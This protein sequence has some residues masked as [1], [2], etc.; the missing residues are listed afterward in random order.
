MIE[1]QQ[2]TALFGIMDW[3]LGHASRSIPVIRAFEDQG[4]K[5]IITSSGRALRLL[6][7]EFPKHELLELP[8]YAPVYASSKHLSWKIAP[9]IPHFMQII[10][11]EKQA[12]ES[13]VQKFK[14]SVVFSDN[15]YGFRSEKVHSIFMTHQL[16]IPL[17]P[18]AK[19]FRPVVDFLNHRYINKFN[20]C[21]VP[22]YAD[23]R[24]FA[25]AMSQ[26]TQKNLRY[27]GWISRFSRSVE[28]DHKPKERD[29]I[30]VL[31]GPEPQRSLFERM[32]I[33]QLKSSD[34]RALIVGGKTEKTGSAQINDRIEHCAYLRAD[35]L[36]AQMLSSKLVICRS[37]YSSLMDLAFLQ[38]NAILVPTPGQTEQEKLAEELSKNNRFYSVSQDR[39][40]LNKAVKAA[41]LMCGFDGTKPDLHDLQ[42]AVAELSDQL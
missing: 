24:S 15:R 12:C 25:G 6:E 8:G 18:E 28:T 34:L 30:A 22:D 21:W 32:L 13:W 38:L 29:I 17:P 27:I 36:E 16:N 39:F 3:G 40:E 42:E 11:R 5:V 19:L 33:E 41:S 23:Q 31:S 2:K 9:Q 14:A 35:E 10:K 4:F 26:S 37:G 20:T 7:A 1:N